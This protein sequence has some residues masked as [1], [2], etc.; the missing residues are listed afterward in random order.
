[1][2]ALPPVARGA[3]MNQPDRRT[4]SRAGKWTFSNA[5]P[6]S[7][8]VHQSG[9]R[10]GAIIR[11]AKRATIAAVSPAASPASRLRSRITRRKVMVS[12]LSVVSCQ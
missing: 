10:A 3:G 7:P 8:G 9:W 4:L 2:V 12:S 5:R 11:R 1:M 6:M